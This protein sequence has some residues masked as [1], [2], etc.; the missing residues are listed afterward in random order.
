MRAGLTQVCRVVLVAP[1][2]PVDMALPAG[3]ALCDLLPT[4]V[5]HARGGR[6]NAGDEWV[7]QRLGESPLDEAGTLAELGVRDGEMLHLRPRDDA[8]PAVHFDDLVDGVAAGM[9]RRRDRWRDWMTRRA[10]LAASG[11]ALLVGLAVLA[12]DGPPAARAGAAG[13]VAVALVAGGAVASRA[14]GDHAAAALLGAGAVPYAGLAGLLAVTAPAPPAL[15]AA[16]AL[17]AGA[18]AG[19][20]ALAAAAAGGV[21]RPGLGAVAVAAWALAGGG[22]LAAAGMT[23]WQAGAVLAAAAVTTGT[24]IPNL[25]FW[26][27]KLRLPALPTGPEDLAADVEPYAVGQ[28]LDRA[29]AADRYM[30]AMFAAAGAVTTAGLSLLAPAVGHT[31]TTLTLAICGVLALRARSMTSAWQRLSALVPAAAGLGLLVVAHASGPAWLA[32]LCWLVIVL[33]AA[34]TAA[35]FARVLPGRRLLPYW[36]RAGDIAEY[37]VAIA[38]VPLALAALGVLGWARALAG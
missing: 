12:L 21:A 19:L 13:G 6:P 28:L 16:N 18:V 26:L 25:A 14:F 3:V 7:L 11:L 30:T 22:L 17:G 35:A 34:G 5:H 2:G 23:A 15:A 38:I 4:L 29:A 10:L 8:L 24:L 20:A 37:V 27:A 31:Q 33:A 9:R 36:G 32:R 1:S